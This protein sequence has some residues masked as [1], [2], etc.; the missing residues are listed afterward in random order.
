[1]DEIEPDLIGL[2]AR[3]KS[4]TLRSASERD[5]MRL[6]VPLQRRQATAVCGMGAAELDGSPLPVVAFCMSPDSARCTTRFQR[7]A[8]GS[9][10]DWLLAVG[11]AVSGA[12]LDA[13]RGVGPGDRYGHH[14]RSRHCHTHEARYSEASGNSRRP[15]SVVRVLTRVAADAATGVS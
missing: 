1:M 9:G 7:G 6:A 5:L 11:G 12:I 13:S 15:R 14:G 10:A 4:L 8:M 3:H 2:L